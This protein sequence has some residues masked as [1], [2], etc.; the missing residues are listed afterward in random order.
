MKLPSYGPSEAIV[1]ARL[2][3]DAAAETVSPQGCAFEKALG[4][5][6]TAIREHDRFKEQAAHERERRLRAERDKVYAHKWICFLYV[7]V[8]VLIVALFVVGGAR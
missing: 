6:N 4:T 5:L 2:V 1:V 8:A 3:E 7:L